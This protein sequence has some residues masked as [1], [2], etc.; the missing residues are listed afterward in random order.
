MEIH[1]ETMLT[2]KELRDILWNYYLFMFTPRNIFLLLLIVFLFPF[3]LLGS[4]GNFLPVLFGF[5]LLLAVL[6]LLLAFPCFWI[7][8]RNRMRRTGC[9]EHPT[10]ELWS[11]TKLERRNG[12]NIQVNEY[13]TCSSYFCFRNRLFLLS[14]NLFFASVALDN[15]PDRGEELIACLRSCGLAKLR[16]WALRRWWRVILMGVLLSFLRCSSQEIYLDGASAAYIPQAEMM[17]ILDDSPS[18]QEL[19]QRIGVPSNRTLLD[20]GGEIWLFRFSEEDMEKHA[21]NGRLPFVAG[22]EFDRQGKLVA[23]QRVWLD[24]RGEQHTEK[25]RAGRNSDGGSDVSR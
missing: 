15:L 19:E 6:K 18:M 11:D 3:V 10:R 13:K 1:L 14:D 17:Q 9:F 5:I 20:N 24:G 7:R 25:F 4:P 12:E 8:T 2:E 23:A 22:F 21:V 16:F